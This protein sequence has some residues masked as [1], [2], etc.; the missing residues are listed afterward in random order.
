[1]S[2]HCCWLGAPPAERSLWRVLLLCPLP[3]LL[4]AG[5]SSRGDFTVTPILYKLCLRVIQ[6]IRELKIS[7]LLPKIKEGS[8]SQLS[9]YSLLQRVIRVQPNPPCPNLPP[10]SSLILLSWSA[11]VLPS[12]PH[13]FLLWF[14]HSKHSPTWNTL[15]NSNYLLIPHS[16]PNPSKKGLSLTDPDWSH[17]SHLFTNY[18]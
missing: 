6:D 12:G 5:F 16:N 4:L 9:K 18:G 15:Q 7:S 1:M 11:Q 10:S 13:A 17:Q 3:S 8:G 14:L 2:S